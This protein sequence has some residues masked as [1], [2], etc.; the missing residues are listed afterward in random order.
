MNNKKSFKPAYLRSYKEGILLEKI[1]D[2]NKTIGN[3]SQ[4]PHKCLVDRRES[5]SGK[6]TSGD[7]PLI[8]SFCAHYGEE[9]PLVGSRGSGTIFFANCNLSC[10]FCQN[11]DISQYGIGEEV[12]HSRLAQIMIHLQNKG[13]HN[14]NFVS[15][16]HMVHSILN[17]LPEAIEMGLRIPLV[18]NSG[19]YDEPAT[20]RL[21]DDV[22][23]IYMPDMK[24]M[25]N[26]I[27]KQFSGVE[28]YVEYATE[29]I[30][31]MYQQ[32]GDLVVDHLG[33]AERGLIIRHLIMPGNISDTKKVIDF[34]RSLSPNTYFNLMDQYHPAYKAKD[35]KSLTRRITS[36]EYTE[37]Y[38]YAISAGLS[39]LAV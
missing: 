23:D 36:N 15:P 5:P 32:V 33:I 35:Y 14:I 26:Q 19:G 27:A 24:Y 16:T 21:L 10:V 2:I 37:A 18:Y 9:S 39:Q 7:K 12:S 6:C 28:N 31:E 30:G 34:V 3:C 25:D 38:E 22:F 8:S 13:C 4:C 1:S 29:S 11:Y 20:I 17:A